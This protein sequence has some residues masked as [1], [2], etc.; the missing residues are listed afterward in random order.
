MEGT[1]GLESSSMAIMQYNA[2]IEN[3]ET[4]AI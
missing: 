4:L 2:L 1:M 3:N